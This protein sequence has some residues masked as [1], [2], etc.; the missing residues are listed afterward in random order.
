MTMYAIVFSAENCVFNSLIINIITQKKPLKIWI[1]YF[2]FFSFISIVYR[3]LNK[4]LSM[5][6][7]INPIF[8]VLEIQGQMKIDIRLHVIIPSATKTRQRLSFENNF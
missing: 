8:S 5:N 2:I 6:Y 1:K 4:V 3:K 7:T